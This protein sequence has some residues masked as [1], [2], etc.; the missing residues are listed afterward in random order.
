MAT[1]NTPGLYWIGGK[2]WAPLTGQICSR[3][4]TSGRDADKSGWGRCAMFPYN[5]PELISQND[6]L[7]AMVM[8]QI[9]QGPHG[10]SVHHCMLDGLRVACTIMPD[11]TPLIHTIWATW[12]GGEVTGFGGAQGETTY[13]GAS[14]REGK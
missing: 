11:G 10:K 7:M 14:A 8:T 5:W 3:E 6:S 9:P 4:G 13:V 1:E 12:T 2:D